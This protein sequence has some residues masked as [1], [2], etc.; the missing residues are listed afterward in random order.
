MLS[1]MLELWPP[2]SSVSPS[3]ALVLAL[4]CHRGEMRSTYPEGT[5]AESGN[6]PW[7]IRPLWLRR[8]R[9][10]L[11]GDHSTAEEC[12]TGKAVSSHGTGR[13]DARRRGCACVQ[14]LLGSTEEAAGTRQQATSLNGRRGFRFLDEWALHSL[15]DAC[16]STQ[17]HI[18][19]QKRAKS[20]A[21]PL[22]STIRKGAKS[23]AIPEKGAKSAACT[24]IA[25]VG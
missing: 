11:A 20:A 15:Q 19:L 22:T 24:A 6:A 5:L 10:G 23:A 21:R 9:C 1:V 7:L 3:M 2:S 17:P 25:T 14:L 12:G 13:A 18:P 16:Y 8:Q 4:S